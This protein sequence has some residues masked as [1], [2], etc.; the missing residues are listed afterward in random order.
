MR[1]E[2]NILYDLFI[3]YNVA[4]PGEILLV[5]QINGRSVE[6]LENILYARKGY[7][8]MQTYIQHYQLGIVEFEII[9]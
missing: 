1:E 4:T 3:K 7:R 5:C 9:N 2:F 6:T 8:N